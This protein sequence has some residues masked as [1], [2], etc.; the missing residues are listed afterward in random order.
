MIRDRLGSVQ[1]PSKEIVVLARRVL[2]PSL[3]GL[4]RV[5]FKVSAETAADL[6]GSIGIGLIR[7]PGKT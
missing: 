5:A 1:K 6:Q 7:S 4:E 3:R 2:P